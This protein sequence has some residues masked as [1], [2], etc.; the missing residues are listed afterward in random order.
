MNSIVEKSLRALASTF[1]DDVAT[2]AVE[3]LVG[4]GAAAVEPLCRLLAVSAITDR[5]TQCDNGERLSYVLKA[6]RLIGDKSAFRPA[7]AFWLE[8]DSFAVGKGTSNYDRKL[9][10]LL[11]FMKAIEPAR[12][13]DISPGHLGDLATTRPQLREIVVRMAGS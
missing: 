12:A 1:D 11:E 4:Q 8:L 6:L 13:S 10:E 5:S 7:A 3:A 2:D 9:L